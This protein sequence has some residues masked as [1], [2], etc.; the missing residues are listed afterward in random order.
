M[1]TSF[2][3]SLRHCEEAMGGFSYVYQTIIFVL[4][5]LCFSS[6]YFRLEL[7]CNH[8][9]RRNDWF[10]EVTGVD[11]LTLKS[12]EMLTHPPS[13]S[14]PSL[15]QPACPCT[16]Y[17]VLPHSPPYKHSSQLT[18][19]QTETLSFYSFT[20]TQGERRHGRTSKD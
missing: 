20:S 18:H 13:T 2:G 9:L 6:S 8:R 10:V 4:V 17:I 3:G 5:F 7:D 12:Q 1:T 14:L 15:C 19:T 16:T 11:L